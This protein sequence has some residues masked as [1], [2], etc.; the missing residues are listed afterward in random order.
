MKKANYHVLVF[1]GN[2][3]E[4]LR[5]V[6][7]YPFDCQGHVLSVRKDGKDWVLDDV[8]SGLSLN[9]ILRFRHTTRKAVIEQAMSYFSTETTLSRLQMHSSMAM[10]VNNPKEV[11]P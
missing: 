10:Q 9:S 11:L 8:R 6:T 1:K 4:A 3:V 2:G 5:K 7:G